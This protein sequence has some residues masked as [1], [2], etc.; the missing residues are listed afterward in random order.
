MRSTQRKRD[1]ARFNRPAESGEEQRVF[2]EGLNGGGKHPDIVIVHLQDD[3]AVIIDTDVDR[4]MEMKADDHI[5]AAG[6]AQRIA[7][8]G[9]ETVDTLD[10]TAIVRQDDLAFVI[11][12][13]W[14]DLAIVVGD[15]ASGPRPFDPLDIDLCWPGDDRGADHG[16][17]A[18]C[19]AEAA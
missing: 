17:K 9:K 5:F 4:R 18:G 1:L 11:D 2:D 15:E 19:R 13:E 8:G 3:Q 12:A 14:P 7:A 6:S 16:G 10:D